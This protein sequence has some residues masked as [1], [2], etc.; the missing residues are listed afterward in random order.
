M[1][2]E[3]YNIKIKEL[4]KQ[5]DLHQNEAY[6]IS[7]EMDELINLVDKS[8]YEWMIGKYIQIDRRIKGGYLGFFHVDKI[9][10]RPRGLTLYGKGFD[11][12]DISIRIDNT[13]TLFE[14]DKDLD[15]I[16]EINESMFYKA[17]DNYVSLMKEKLY[18]YKD[19]ELVENK[20]KF[21]NSLIKATAE[22]HDKN[23]VS[24]K[25]LEILKSN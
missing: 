3:E 12:S 7:K 19:Y 24:N 23:T 5:R 20:L 8:S 11:I 10:T 1:N 14:E 6:R 13:Y 15:M 25:V 4:R 9:E 2:R 21:K 16:T 17:F 18:N 22:L